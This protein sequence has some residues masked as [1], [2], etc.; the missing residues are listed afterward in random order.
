M[1]AVA[2]EISDWAAGAEISVFRSTANEK[3]AWDAEA[4]NFAKADET[5][6][7]AGISGVYGILLTAHH[8]VYLQLVRSHCQFQLLRLTWLRV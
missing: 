5:K 1:E 3:F 2:G 8:H 4:E 6:K 7:A